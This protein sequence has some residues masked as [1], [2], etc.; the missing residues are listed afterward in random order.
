MPTLIDT[1]DIYSSASEALSVEINLLGI[2]PH[3]SP[4]KFEGW[5]RYNIALHEGK[6]LLAERGSAIH[7][8]D[9][10]FLEDLFSNLKDRDEE[11]AP[12]EPD[13][14]LGVSHFNGQDWILTCMLN[15]GSILHTYHI[16]SALG[17][18]LR[19]TELEAR[20]FADTL[21]TQRTEITSVF[22]Q[23]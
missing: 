12:M 19:I 18:R 20:D 17:V 11:F 22:D 5:I 1:E 10:K 14:S 2:E 13:F 3:Q 16:R 23:N 4:A 15:Y 7:V 8:D 6:K 9:I 21:K